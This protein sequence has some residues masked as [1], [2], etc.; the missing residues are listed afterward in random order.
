MK[1]DK[2][3]EFAGIQ[4]YEIIYEFIMLRNRMCFSYFGND[5][6]LN[7]QNKTLQ[8]LIIEL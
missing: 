5:S 6:Y 7:R 2:I 3:C 4:E 1:E 8:M